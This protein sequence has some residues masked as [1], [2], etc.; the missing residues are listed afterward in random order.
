MDNMDKVNLLQD[1]LDEI[2]L[3]PNVT[4]FRLNDEIVTNALF[5]QRIAPIMNE[6]DA[7]TMPVLPLLMEPDIEVVSAV[8]AAILLGKP[9]IP[10]NPSWSEAQ[11]SQVLADAGIDVCLTAH[12]M[13]YFFR[14]TFE[15]ALDR[16]DNGFCELNPASVAAK[17][18][19]FDDDGLMSS[20]LLTL[21]EMLDGKP[22]IPAV[23]DFC[24][25]FF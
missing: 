16:V 9:V 4:A 10:I 3:N 18:Y 11:R 13:Q 2:R 22:F 23:V 5:L 7:V 19:A 8:P 17:L 15:D 24:R 14:M 12:R 25:S 6:L 21:G 1:F 20:R